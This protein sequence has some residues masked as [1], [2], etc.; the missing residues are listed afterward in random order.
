MYVYK[1][2]KIFAFH[3]LLVETSRQNKQI[4]LSSTLVVTILVIAKL[5]GIR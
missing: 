2:Y 1:I 3:S 5:F 4:L